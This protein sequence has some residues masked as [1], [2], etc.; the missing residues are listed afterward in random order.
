MR[1]HF[2]GCVRIRAVLVRCEWSFRG[3]AR[4]PTSPIETEKS[5][6]S[7]DSRLCFFAARGVRRARPAAPLEATRS[8]RCSTG[9]SVT[10][11][12]EFCR[13]RSRISVEG[14]GRGAV[15]LKCSRA[16]ALATL[17]RPPAVQKLSQVRRHDGA[18]MRGNFEGVAA[19]VRRGDH[20]RK[21]EQR[22]I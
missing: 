21:L 18:L 7:P 11:G 1:A 19:D 2:I 3:P 4:G 16:S 20:I 17:A 22:M 5:F 6:L 10:D 8:A 14:T 13:S 12:R 15:Q 9:R